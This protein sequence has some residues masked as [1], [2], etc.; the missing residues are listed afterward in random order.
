MNKS[1][2][3]IILISGTDRYQF[4]QGLITQDIN[5]INTLYSIPSAICNIK[6]RVISTCNIVKLKDSIGLAVPK[7]ITNKV[8]DHLSL[9]QLRSDIKIKNSNKKYTAIAVNIKNLNSKSHSDLFTLIDNLGKKGLIATNNSK[10][11]RLHR[12]LWR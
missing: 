7:S 4:L 10:K 5:R 3:N 9:Y 6:G 11:K 12:N 8:I 1:I 2:Y